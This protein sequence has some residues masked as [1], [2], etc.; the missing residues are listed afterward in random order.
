M[1]VRCRDLCA[2]EALHA[3]SDDQLLEIWEKYGSGEVEQDE[4]W[5]LAF[6]KECWSGR[7]ISL[8]VDTTRGHLEFEISEEDKPLMNYNSL[9]PWVKPD[10]SRNDFSYISCYGQSFEGYKFAER[11]GFELGDFANQRAEDYRKSGQ[12]TGDFVTLRSCLFFELR[13][14]RHC[15]LYVDGWRAIQSLF[16]AVCHAYVNEAP[17][18]H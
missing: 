16:K 3:Q 11:A 6:L 5:L 10:C 15:G 17:S 18:N 8:P 1:S 9:D 4:E 12:W 13:R 2:I 7:K 14:Q